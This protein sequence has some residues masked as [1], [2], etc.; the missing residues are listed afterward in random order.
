VPHGAGATERIVSALLTAPQPPE[1]LIASNGVMLTAALRA[2]RALGAAAPPGLAMAG[3]D[4]EPWMDCLSTGLAVI[5]QPVEEIG[6][7]AMAM[8][9]DRLEHAEAPVRKVVLRGQL[10]LREAGQGTPG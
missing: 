8:L 7:S 5:E 3:F 4:N 2:V 1:A 9:M 6:R 10:V